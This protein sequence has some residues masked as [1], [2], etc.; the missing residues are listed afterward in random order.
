MYTS[1]GCTDDRAGTTRQFIL[2]GLSI[3]S[4]RPL[5]VDGVHRVAQKNLNNVSAESA[6]MG[7]GL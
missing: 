4:C 6:H 2:A 5:G 1:M 3:N 7:S